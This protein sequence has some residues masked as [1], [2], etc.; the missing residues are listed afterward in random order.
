MRARW[1]KHS[2]ENFLLLRAPSISIEV[3]RPEAFDDINPL[4][5]SKFSA[6]F[7]KQKRLEKNKDQKT[8]GQ[9]PL[10]RFSKNV[11]K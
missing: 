2:L 8:S 9:S 3:I 7:K 10:F 6:F 11:I 5:G 1:E 4:E